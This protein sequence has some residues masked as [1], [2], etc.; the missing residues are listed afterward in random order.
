MVGEVA[1]ADG[2]KSRDGCLE[3]VVNPDAAHCVVDGRENHHW[4]VII[5]SI[6]CSALFAW[7][8]VGNLLIHVEEVAITLTNHVDA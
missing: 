5:H 7:V 2:E 4:I 3:F 6:L 1:L 8:H